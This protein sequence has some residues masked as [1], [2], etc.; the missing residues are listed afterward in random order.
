MTIHAGQDIL[1]QF[2]FLIR[3]GLY[4]KALIMTKEEE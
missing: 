4:D 2:E 3:H 1:N